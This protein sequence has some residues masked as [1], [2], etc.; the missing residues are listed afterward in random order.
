MKEEKVKIVR[1]NVQ[2]HGLNATLNAIWLSKN[3]WYY[4]HNRRVSYEEK[5]EALKDPLIQVLKQHP[6]Y[7]YQRVES[8]VKKY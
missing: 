5:Y 4:W 6:E 8:Q 7:G 3:T 2:K 1:E